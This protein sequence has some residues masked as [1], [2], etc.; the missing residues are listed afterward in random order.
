MLT[1][2]AGAKRPLTRDDI[3]DQAGVSRTSSGLGQGLRELSAMELIV[4]DP[5]GRYTLNAALRPASRSTR[6]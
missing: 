3:A 5:Q 4:R 6:P 1:A 2:I